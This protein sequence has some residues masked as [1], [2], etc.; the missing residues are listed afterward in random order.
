MD[1]VVLFVSGGGFFLAGALAEKAN[2]RRMLSDMHVAIA[3]APKREEEANVSRH[4]CREDLTM[5]DVHE[6]FAVLESLKKG[7]SKANAQRHVCRE[8]GAVS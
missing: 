4:V 5:G 6:D 3:S 7:E 8:V 1:S 2:A